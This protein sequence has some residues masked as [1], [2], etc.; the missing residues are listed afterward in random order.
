MKKL[1]GSTRAEE[2]ISK[3][4][5]AKEDGIKN[6]VKVEYIVTGDDFRRPLK[7]AS[8]AIAKLRRYSRSY[9]WNG[10]VSVAFVGENGRRYSS[11]SHAVRF[12]K[13]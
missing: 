6:G 11:A 12:G 1:V 5:K 9:I 7:T 4:L 10:W 13:K 2:A 3:I 8:G